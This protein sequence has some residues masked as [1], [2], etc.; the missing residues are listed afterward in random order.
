MLLLV[1]SSRVYLALS[2]L[3]MLRR[4]IRPELFLTYLQD[5]AMDS[6]LAEVTIVSALPDRL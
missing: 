6:R 1:S 3:G 5:S 4:E 2:P